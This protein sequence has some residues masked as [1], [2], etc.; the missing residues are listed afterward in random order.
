MNR[1]VQRPSHV[2]PSILGGCFRTVI[3]LAC[4]LGSAAPATADLLPELQAK[5]VK[6]RGAGGLVGLEGYQTGVII[7]AEGHILTPLSYVLE[8]GDLSV[9]CDDGRRLAVEMLGADPTLE[10]AVLKADADGLPAFDVGSPIPA[11]PGTEI[12]ILSNAFGVA[13]GAESVA[14][15]RATVAGITRLRAKRGAFPIAYDGPVLL[16]DM[17]T[18]NPGAAGGAVVDHRGRLLGLVGKELRSSLTGVW[19]N[20]ALPLDEISA[21]ARAIVAGQRRPPVA[22][23][24]RRKPAR[25]HRLAD[26]GLVLVPHVVSLT[27][28]YIDSVD[29]HGPAAAAGLL[30]DDL[31]VLVGDDLV[32]SIAALEEALAALDAGDPVELTVRRVDELIR[33]S[34]LAPTRPPGG[35]P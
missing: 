4:A 2:A 25:S 28:P 8:A 6:I 14:A 16:L 26:L 5:V 22:A 9:V 21:A 3:A 35:S 20:Y 12:W 32:Q 27:P 29:P 18:S 17:V 23:A 34:L 7:S 30:P 33:V 24:Q 11:L 31:I 10:I 13:S 19:M 15:Q 1:L